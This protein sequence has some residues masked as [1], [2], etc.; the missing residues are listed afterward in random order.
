[1]EDTLDKISAMRRMEENGYVTKDWL[2][3]PLQRHSINLPLHW[4]DDVVDNECRVKMAGWCHQVVKFCKFN[5]ET[6]EITMSMIDRFLATE[7]GLE[8]RND[9]SI[10]QLVCMAALY[11]TFKVHEERAMSPELVSRLSNGSHSA[12]DIKAMEKRMLTALQWRVNP[13]TSFA[14]VR[15][16][17]DLIPQDVLDNT[18]RS[19]VLELAQIQTE[20]AMS[21]SCFM[22]VRA[23]QMAYAALMNALDCVGV[24]VDCLG[25]LGYLLAQSVQVDG[26]SGSEMLAMQGV[27]YKLV[28]QKRPVLLEAPTNSKLSSSS[29]SPLNSAT[30]KLPLSPRTVAHAQ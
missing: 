28:A 26:S 19:T 9:R 6:V 27:L 16:L 5:R 2:N 30:H 1:M 12:S 13:P 10:Y 22:T 18:M 21:N 14:F 29:S 11:T 24:H 3:M 23:S 7:A 8:A 4:E 20:L 15:L 25:R 17:V